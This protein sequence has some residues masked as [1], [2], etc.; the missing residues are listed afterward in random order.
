MAARLGTP[1][2]NLLPVDAVHAE[3]IPH[4]T[5]TIGARTEHI[6]LIPDAGGP[7]EIT[8]V[9]HL[10]SE[11]HLHL[12]MNGHKLITLTQPHQRWEPGSRARVALHRPLCFNAAGESLT[13]GGLH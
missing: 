6:E 12:R 3:G 2:I 4:A 10:G 11:N 1:P 9:E 7:A 5:A 13:A 8:Q